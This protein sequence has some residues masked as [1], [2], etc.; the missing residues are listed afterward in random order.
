MYSVCLHNTLGANATI[1]GIV[2]SINNNA[3]IRGIVGSI[4]NNGT[5]GYSGKYQL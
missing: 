3:T 4:N 5:I 2:G 1:R